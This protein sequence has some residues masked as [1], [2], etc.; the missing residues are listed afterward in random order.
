MVKGITGG[1][2][3]APGPKKM[4]SND[5]NAMKAAMERGAREK[6]RRE[7]DRKMRLWREGRRQMEKKCIQHGLPVPG[8]SPAADLQKF[9]LLNHLYTNGNPQ[10]GGAGRCCAGP[11]LSMRNFVDGQIG[12]HHQNRDNDWRRR[13]NEDHR[14]RDAAWHARQS[15]LHN[16]ENNER[17]KSRMQNIAGTNY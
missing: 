2:P 9:G 8:K 17:H 10:G 15:R 5:K 3:G 4:N 12:G 1:A 7:R 14:R 13:E 11:P 16:T 6:Q